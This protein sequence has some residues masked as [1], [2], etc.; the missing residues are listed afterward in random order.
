MIVHQ[1]FVEQTAG[2]T[3]QAAL[4]RRETLREKA[5]AFIASELNEEDIISITETAIT[6]G[7]LFSVTVWYKKGE[8]A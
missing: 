4:A 8:P 1:T 6:A 2:L 3:G 7:G 5:E